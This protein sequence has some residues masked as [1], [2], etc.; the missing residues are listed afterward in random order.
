MEKGFV[1]ES[2]RI[3]TAA[4][5]TAFTK[6]FSMGFEDVRLT[7]LVRKPDFAESCVRALTREGRPMHPLYMILLDQVASR[8]E[9]ICGPKPRKTSEHPSLPAAAEIRVKRAA[10][11][12][13]A[14]ACRQ[15]TRTEVR[16]LRPDLW[17]WLYRYDRAWLTDNQPPCLRTGNGRLRGVMPVEIANAIRANRH[18]RRSGIRDLE[19]LSSSYQTRLSYGMSDWAFQRATELLGG[20][21]KTASIPAAKEVFA[22]RRVEAAHRV[23]STASAPTTLAKAASLRPATV[24]RFAQPR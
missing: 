23:Y 12:A 6:V 7:G 19:P 13:H 20:A 18:D 10:W 15:L 3:R 21:G 17:T 9:V 4:L 22:T 14:S 16:K 8:A 1:F 2:G 11:S 5:H 24:E